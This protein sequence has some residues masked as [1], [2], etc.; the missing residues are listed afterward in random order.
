M[1]HLL[2]NPLFPDLVGQ[3]AAKPHGAAAASSWANDNADELD[4]ELADP[5]FIV[6]A[7]REIAATRLW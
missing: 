1:K 7:Q 2:M 6:M 3:Y 5:L 4:R